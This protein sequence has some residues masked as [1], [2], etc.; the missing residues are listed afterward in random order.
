VSRVKT[1]EDQEAEATRAKRASDQAHRKEEIAGMSPEDQKRASKED[2]EERTRE[3]KE[4]WAGE[5]SQVLE[6]E[7]TDSSEPIDTPDE[8]RQE[9]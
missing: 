8:P 5:Q 3:K 7:D 1:E 4:R 9:D 2:Y 6:D